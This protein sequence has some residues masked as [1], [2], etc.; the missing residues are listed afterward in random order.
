[1]VETRTPMEMAYSAG[2]DL[3]WC[4]IVGLRTS[5]RAESLV[6]GCE[7]TRR[8]RQMV[9]RIAGNRAKGLSSAD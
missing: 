2:R 7:K 8:S 1:M 4:N 3:T 9:R 5:S 6:R